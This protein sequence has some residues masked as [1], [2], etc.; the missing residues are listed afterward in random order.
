MI[1]KIRA[2]FDAD[3]IEA[4]KQTEYETEL[5]R[6]E[7]PCGVCGKM[8]FVDKET[9]GNYEKAL[10]HDLDNQFICADCEREYEDLAYE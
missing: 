3:M 4:N 8:L 5:N 6:F 7:L 1:P 9:L 10:E 2:E